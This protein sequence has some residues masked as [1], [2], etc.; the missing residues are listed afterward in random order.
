MRLGKSGVSSCRAITREE[1]RAFSEVWRSLWQKHSFPV[2]RAV[3]R[4]LEQEINSKGR[5]KCKTGFGDTVITIPKSNRTVHDPE[6]KT[7]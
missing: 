2:T 1:M 7:F 6:D 4:G 3:E 5:G